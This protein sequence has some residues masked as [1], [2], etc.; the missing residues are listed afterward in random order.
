[1]RS[2]D[3][4]VNGDIPG[5]FRLPGTETS[6]RFYGFAE[7]NLVHEMKGDNSD[8][9]Y[10]TFL[11]YVPLNGSAQGDR[12]GMTYLTGRTSRIGFEASTPSSYGPATSR[13]KATST[14]NRTPAIPQCTATSRTSSRNKRPTATT[15]ACAMPTVS[16]AAC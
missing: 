5:S 12:R 8:S 1:L 11:P 16:W 14:T 2:K 10:S 13:S 3:A 4:V 9:D 6:L 15:S 7:L